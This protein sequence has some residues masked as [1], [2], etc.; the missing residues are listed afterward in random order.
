MN[1]TNVIPASLTKY[2]AAETNIS[3]FNPAI[4]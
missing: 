2:V 4:S 3:G 1:Y